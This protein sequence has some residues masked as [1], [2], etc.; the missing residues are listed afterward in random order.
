MTPE[1]EGDY[2]DPEKDARPSSPGLAPTQI[3]YKL[4]ESPP[5]YIP[6]SSS[7]SSSSPSV[8]PG[9]AEGKGGQQGLEASA[10]LSGKKNPKRKRRKGRTRPSQGDAVLISYLDPNRPDIARE[11]AQRALNSASQSE[12]EDDLERDMNGDGKCEHN[13]RTHDNHQ[14]S[15]HATELKT[16]A[17]AAL[18]DVTAGDAAPER[19][20]L[21]AS[22]TTHGVVQ[23]QGSSNGSVVQCSSLHGNQDSKTPLRSLNPALPLKIRPPSQGGEEEEE[24]GEDES[25][26]TSPALAKFA[27]S[28]AEANPD[29]TL[30]AMQKSPPRSASTHS[31]DGTQSLPSLKTT[32][33]QIADTPIP[34]AP[35]GASPFSQNSVQSPNLAR[36][37]HVA[38]NPGPSPRMYSNP[39]PASSK[40]ITSMSPPGCPN[41]PNYW[42]STP[43]EGSFSTA[44]PASAAGLNQVTSYPTP[45]D[46]VSPESSTSP[47]TLNGTLSASE[48]FTST[49]FKC[50]HPGCTAQPFQTQYLLNSHANVHSSS[51]PHYCPIKTCSRS[52]GGK[53]FKRKNEMIRHGLVHQSPGYVCPFCAD[54]QHKYPRPDN[55]QR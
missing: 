1:A 41:Y 18:N 17:W 47:Q 11:F 31:P 25:I 27:I 49:A 2:Y 12:A 35:N 40:D 5:P 23:K 10:R 6:T 26:A 37:H 3:S 30:P 29:S 16:T 4:E 46:I 50:T 33:S 52:F 51:R 53:G 13:G 43:K 48:P 24:E 39:S 44:S 14:N 22:L 7:S 42:R 8:S 34:E 20:V 28:A 54:Q 38:G 15:A 9:P 45:K 36:S 55:L 21:S 19:N 32:L